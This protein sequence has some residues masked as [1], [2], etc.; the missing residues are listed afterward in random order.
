MTEIDWN[1]HYVRGELPWDSCDPDPHL[2]EF[3]QSGVVSPGRALDI[4]SGTGTNTLWLA[5]QGFEATGVDISPRAIEL[6]H[7]KAG[8]SSGRYAFH[9]LDILS[10]PVPGD[11]FD[12]VFDRGC[13]HVF[14]AAEDRARFAERVAAVLRPGGV[15][16]SVSGSTEGEPRDFGPPRR[17]ARDI[18]LAVEPELEILQ[19]RDTEFRDLPTPTRAWACLSRRRRVPAQPSSVR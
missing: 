11:A 19:L 16:L 5:A 4:G 10:D 17:S 1:E 13:F 14:D 7:A 9:V 12:F 15:W 18:V 3:V 8:G 6:A 2:V